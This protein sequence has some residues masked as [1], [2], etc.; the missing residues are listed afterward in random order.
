MITNLG[1]KMSVD[2]GQISEDINCKCRL[3]TE[4]GITAASPFPNGIIEQVRI[5]ELMHGRINKKKKNIHTHV[6]QESDPARDD[7]YFDFGKSN[8]TRVPNDFV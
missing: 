4:D 5:S 7:Y 2:L 8:E 1:T 3:D 6:N